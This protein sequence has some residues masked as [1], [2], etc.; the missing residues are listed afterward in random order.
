MDIQQHIKELYESSNEFKR[1]F[2]SDLPEMVGVEAVNHFTESFQNE[3]FTD[4]GLE[5]WTEVKRRID[6]K[7]I[8]RA[9]AS[10][11]IL[12]GDTGDLGRSIEAK[13]QPGEVKITADTTAAGS[14]KDYAAAHNDGTTTAGRGNSTTIPKRQFIGKSATLDKKILDICEKKIASILK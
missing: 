7:R 3:G 9:A 5:K 6:P 2:D 1:W 13:A 8:D 10:R 4:T 11:K 12:T 14:D